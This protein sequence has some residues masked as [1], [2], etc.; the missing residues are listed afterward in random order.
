[1]SPLPD[2]DL[3][4]DREAARQSRN[5]D[6]REIMDAGAGKRLLQLIELVRAFSLPIANME[7]TK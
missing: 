6:A 2:R 3:R 7:T 5:T 4:A 1:M